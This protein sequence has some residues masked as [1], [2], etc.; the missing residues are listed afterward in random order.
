MRARVLLLFLFGGSLCLVCSLLLSVLVCPPCGAPLLSLRDPSRDP[1]ERSFLRSD[2]AA[3]LVCRRFDSAPSC[4]QV[5]GSVCSS[6]PSTLGYTRGP[7]RHGRWASGSMWTVGLRTAA[8]CWCRASLAGL[9][10]TG[11]VVRKRF[12]T[13]LTDQSSGSTRE[14][15]RSKSCWAQRAVFRDACHQNNNEISSRHRS[16]HVCPR[17]A[18]TQ[19]LLR[20]SSRKSRVWRDMV[21]HAPRPLVES[22]WTPLFFFVILK[23]V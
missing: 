21:F 19:P 23:A 12:R 1:V 16:V 5:V 18:P 13:S 3:L 11:R 10:F 20:R 17:L 2:H 4:I 14:V 7:Q 6:P 22:A 9:V 15:R 8:M